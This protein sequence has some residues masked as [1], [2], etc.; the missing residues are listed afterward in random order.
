MRFLGEAVLS[1]GRLLR[2]RAQMRGSDLVLFIQACGAEAVGIVALINFLVGL[3]LGYVGV[4]QLEL[5][6]AQIYSADLV[7]IAVAREM[8]AIMTGIIMA[9]RTG[10]AFAAQLGTMTVNEEIDALSTLGVS[11]FDFLVL[12]RMLAL[13]VMVPLLAFTPMRS[14]SSAARWPPFLGRH[15]PPLY[16]ERTLAALNLTDSSIGVGK[17]VV[18]GIIVALAGCLRGI[19]SGRSA[20]AVGEA[21]TSAVVTAIVLIIVADGGVRGGLRHGGNLNVANATERSPNQG[22]AAHVGIRRLRRQRDVD[23][24]VARGSDLHPHGRQRQREEHAHAPH[25]RAATAREGDVLYGGESF[26]GRRRGAAQRDEA[27]LRRALPERRAVELDDS[28]RERGASARR[29]HRLQRRGAPRGRGFKL[30]LVGL[31]GFEEFYPSEI[32]GGMQKRAGLA[33][34]M[35]LDP[36]IL[37]FD[38]PSAGLDPVTSRRLDDLILELRD[39]LGTTFV[40]VTHELASIF[41]IADDS[42]FVDAEARTMTAR[43]DPRWLR[44]HRRREVRQFLNRGAPAGACVGGRP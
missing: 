37:F 21:A 34:A 2:G 30:A 9:G 6:S 33:R 23:F 25:D 5:F 36:D 7:A 17:S 39:S 4:Q 38:E 27:A 26:W 24:E 22:A 8:G 42:I 35:A 13:T 15:R 44:E 41:A 18:F 14:A 11:A 16:W 29:V 3:I 10:A 20:Q 19:Q 12:P 32:S 31:A 40:V 28:R 1:V 43:G